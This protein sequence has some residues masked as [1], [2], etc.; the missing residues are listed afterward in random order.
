FGVSCGHGNAKAPVECEM[1]APPS[2]AYLL[3]NE[4]YPRGSCAI[5]R[6]RCCRGFLLL[7]QCRE[8]PERY[9]EA[10]TFSAMIRRN[11]RSTRDGRGRPR[12]GVRERW[13][14]ASNTSMTARNFETA[15]K[16][17]FRDVADALDI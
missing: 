15:P 7:I 16:S 13:L 10:V 2:S 11:G 6:V 8:R 12:E 4:R 9:G 14:P 3:I 1:T 17:S 5:G